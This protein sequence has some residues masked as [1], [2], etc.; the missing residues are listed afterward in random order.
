MKRNGTLAAVAFSLVL[1]ACTENRE[2]ATSSTKNVEPAQTH[3]KNLLWTVEVPTVD[4]KRA[5]GFYQSILGVKL[6]EMDMGGTRMGI[7]PSEDGAVSLVLVNGEGY[8]P[9]GDGTTAYLETGDDLQ[10]VLSKVAP[11]GGQVIVPKTEISPEMG[12]FALFIDTE[13]NKIGLHSDH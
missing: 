5:I 1:S 4:L 11:S 7:F 3:M 12:F 13:G 2:S 6:E 9:S 8:T 10:S